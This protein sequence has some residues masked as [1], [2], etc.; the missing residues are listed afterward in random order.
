MPAQNLSLSAQWTAI[1]N[2]ILEASRPPGTDYRIKITESDGE[3]QVISNYGDADEDEYE[4]NSINV[5]DGHSYTI[6]VYAPYD[7]MTVVSGLIGNPGRWAPY[8]YFDQNTIYP[9]YWVGSFEGRNL[10]HLKI[11]MLKYNVKLDKQ[12]GTGG[13]DGISAIYNADMPYAEMPA[14]DGYAFG[15]YYDQT[16]GRGNKYYDAAG[17]S[18]RRWD[19]NFSNSTGLNDG[20]SDQAVLYAY[21]TP[22][23]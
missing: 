1:G 3:T 4:S 10:S 19:K 23:T 7:K 8:A 13:S 15:G 20:L 12:G 22:N 16:D 2:F 14:R 5:I 18:A 6:Y 11:K 17:N 21:W 9:Y